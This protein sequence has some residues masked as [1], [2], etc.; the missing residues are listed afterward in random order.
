MRNL[1]YNIGLDIGTS[2]VGWA[3]TDL[4]NNL[5]VYNNKK[6]NGK[7][8]HQRMWGSLLFDEGVT[9]K[10]RRLFRSA[11]RRKARM[12]ERISI[13]QHI[14]ENEINQVDPIFFRRL[15]ESNLFLE[16]RKYAND[17]LG[18]F[19]NKDLYES[20]YPTIYHLRN[21]I[22]NSNEK[23]D[24]RLVYLAIHHIIKYRGNFLYENQ[25]F[26][27]KDINI[28]EQFKEM[29][30]LINQKQYIFDT[31]NEIDYEKVKD[32]VT[33]GNLSNK[34]RMEQLLS[35]ITYDS[36]YKNTVKNI[37]ALLVGL[38]GDL[39]KIFDIE[40]ENEEELKLLS[41]VKF[42]DSKYSETENDIIN[43]LGD[44][45]II[46]EKIK[47]LY[48]SIF[49]I[50][51]FKETKNPSLSTV[52]IE[53]YNKHKKDLKKLK[54]AI[55]EYDSI[56][57]TNKY[58]EFFR[59]HDEG[60]NY[61]T[62]IR[63]TKKY[64]YDEIKKDIKTLIK[65]TRNEKEIIE[66]LEK[67]N[68]LQKLNIVENSLFP[69]QLNLD[70]LYK[71]IE[72]QKKYY[73]FLAD[74]MEL[75]GSKIYKLERLLTFRIPYYVGP[76]VANKF[77]EGHKYAWF[78]RKDNNN[79][80]INP[81]NFEKIVDI[82]K[83]AENF[84]TRMTNFCTYLPLEKVIP[85]NSLLYSEFM[86]LNELK[87]I[88][89]NDK[90]ISLDVQKN[91]LNNLF[92][93]NGGRKINNRNFINWL[94]VN[95]I[96]TTEDVRI[97][98]YQSEDGFSSSLKSYNDFKKVINNIDDYNNTL[99]IE[100]IIEW[101]TIY[102]DKKI[103]RARIKECYGDVLDS[104]QIDKILTF[105]YSGW[106]NIS[107]KML[108]SADIGYEDDTT[109]EFYS[110]I[111]LMRD[112]TENFMQII[113]NPKYNIQSQ[114]KEL[115]YGDK[116]DDIT[117]DD[118]VD[119]A[120]SPA[121][122]K[123]IWQSIL[124]VKEIIDIMGH[125]PKHI[126]LEFAREDGK[127]VRT[128]NRNNQIKLLYEGIKSEVN[129]FNSNNKNLL[130]E[131]SEQDNINDEKLFLYFLQQGKSLY[132]GKMLNINDLSSYEVDH[133]IPRCL[134]KDD[135]IDNKALVLKEENQRKSDGT[136]LPEYQ[137]KCKG[138]WY[139][140]SKNHFI[141]EKKYKSLCLKEFTPEIINGFI[142]RQLVETRQI[143]K[144]VTNI[145]NQY[146]GNDC[147]CA[148]KANISHDFRLKHHMYK[149]R[150]LNNLHHAHD[151]YLSAALGNLMLKIIPKDVIYSKYNFK[152]SA[153]NNYN[154][155]YGWFISQ[156][157]EDNSLKIAN[158]LFY[159]DP[160]VIKKT[161]IQ[162][163]EFYNQ[164][165]YSRGTA[166]KL[167][168]INK[169]LDTSKYGGYTGE[170]KGYFIL[171]EYKKKNIKQRKIISIP[172]RFSKMNDEEKMKYIKDE[173]KYDD[174]II[175]KDRI[176]KN[177]LIEFKNQR[178]YLSSD[179]ELVNAVEL[180]LKKDEQIEYRDLLNYLFN[181]KLQKN[182]TR[183][184]INILDK[185]DDLINLLLDKMKNN[186]FAYENEYKKIKEF[187]DLIG[188]NNINDENKIKLFKQLVTIMKSSPVTGDLKF[189]ND[190][191]T[192]YKFSDRMGRR[193][194][195]TL[196]SGKIILTSLTG[197]R[198]NTIIISED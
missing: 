43:I 48:T 1:E 60:R 150:D 105:N 126:Y 61:E 72:S 71:I 92:K 102:E 181:G 124:L 36:N 141:S 73:P 113:N 91:I 97:T 176:G 110:V 99:M 56:N 164:T 177:Q 75:N 146:L 11:R 162:T 4:N 185:I 154:N 165:L 8:K 26:S 66:D 57:N 31:E 143:I 119:L 101:I 170:N 189:L 169:K 95:G 98:G 93:C 17:K 129:S 196:T 54:N 121:V 64:S 46:L 139:Y 183:N 2:S 13:L 7:T 32:I 79:E 180:H 157:D 178:F 21:K 96:I 172:I 80:R 107:R 118:I 174:P 47:D 88:K 14:F 39:T 89:I 120:C 140:L 179:T 9:A 152:Y 38:Q 90:R 24:I 29:F 151:A 3:V 86:V 42:S 15:E 49:L 175:I 195:Q 85:K 173:L 84:I 193:A 198:T 70:E 108:D 35:V 184:N 127:N 128:T 27:L 149:Y 78:E 53:R 37:I 76:I 45:Y 50:K 197:L 62:Y 65:D 20:T 63:N 160:I 134:I 158:T 161:E 104:K 137:N 136:L 18:I 74:Q 192:K 116:K 144:N 81:F 40:T 125:K 68:F 25:K 109:G 191:Q 163:G 145:L 115:A 82:N 117:Y 168:A 153:E 28:N 123:G 112:T 83:S 16:D 155:K 166:G 138:W 194:M 51:I 186:Y 22:C 130:K 122:K 34:E 106:S 111:S 167:V 10:Q 12:H 188:L 148:V 147:V 103:I 77:M 100:K 41:K 142:N 23:I 67:D 44:D 159:N 5:V 55:L 59:I 6:E 69:F 52:M 135:S 156:I 58:D 133:I 182:A 190:L 33:N 132:S 171:I 187:I 19:S 30:E 94:Y 114:I 87:Q 131:L